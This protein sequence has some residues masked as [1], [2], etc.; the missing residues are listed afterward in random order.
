MT[1]TNS[2]FIKRIAGYVR[3]AERSAVSARTDTHPLDG[4]PAGE[5]EDVIGLAEKATREISGWTENYPIMGETGRRNSRAVWSCLCAASTFPSG[6]LSL[7]VDYAVLVLAGFAHDDVMDGSFPGY[8]YPRLAEFTERCRQAAAGQETGEP[9]NDAERQV[10]TAYRDGFRRV[11]RYPA[12]TWADHHLMRLWADAL[13]SHLQQ[14]RWRLRADPAP[15]LLTYLSNGVRSI[16]A[17]AFGALTLAMSDLPR[18]D[19]HHLKAWDQAT[20]LSGLAIRLSN[21]LATADRDREEGNHSAVSLLIEAGHTREQ[22]GVV[23]SEVVRAVQSDLATAV[24]LLPSRLAG[25]GDALRRNTRFSCSWYQVLDTAGMTSQHLRHL[26]STASTEG[27][28]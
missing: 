18:L 14:A 3:I 12:A 2:D 6:P 10:I 15:D 19:E 22:A 13:N 20:H 9:A 8:T 1:T 4:V 28:S 21:D 26:M 5:L 11:R 16:F 25:V 7:I 23:V 27:T 17:P 24:G